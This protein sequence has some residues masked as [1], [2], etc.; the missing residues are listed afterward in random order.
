MN[1]QHPAGGHRLH[2]AA[3]VL[4][5]GCSSLKFARNGS[6]NAAAFHDL[7]QASAN[8]AIEATSRGLAVHQMVGI[9]PDRAR[10][11]YRIPEGVQALT[12]LAIGYAADP[13]SVPEA[14]RDR[15]KARR[16]RKAVATFVFGD[17]WGTASS[18]AK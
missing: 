6:P 15:E 7:G 10:E 1:E 2:P 8:L 13:D 3:P 12:G 5:L 16:P 17:T 9:L 11:L 4:A 14:L 18:V